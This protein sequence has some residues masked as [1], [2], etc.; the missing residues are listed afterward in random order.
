MD[1]TAKVVVYPEKKCFLLFDRYD[2]LPTEAISLNLYKMS[3]L[4]NIQ[5]K[6]DIISVLDPS[7]VQANMYG[8]IENN[9]KM[10]ITSIA[11]EK[12]NV[13]PEVPD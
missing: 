13:K 3:T 9:T 4:Q 1:K 10:M 6:G 12:G 7:V 11:A 8:D 2:E 5:T